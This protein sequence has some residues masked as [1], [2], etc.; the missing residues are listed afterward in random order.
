MGGV[1]AKLIFKNAKE[2]VASEAKS[3]WEIGAKNIDGEMI[4]PL[5]T[6]VNG[7]K[8]VMVVNVATN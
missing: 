6:L 7:K 2:N 5:Q 4:D 8:C 3:A 1:V